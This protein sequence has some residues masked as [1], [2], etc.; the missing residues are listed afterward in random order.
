[1][2]QQYYITNIET[3]WTVLFS[4]HLPDELLVQ[5]S[6]EDGTQQTTKQSINEHFS[7]DISWFTYGKS[8]SHCIT[9]LL[10]VPG[11]RGHK[12]II[13]LDLKAASDIKIGKLYRMN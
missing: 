13:F 12:Y 1:M 8:V 6:F 5:N 2:D 10:T 3:Y 11:D 7:P 9:T 4:S